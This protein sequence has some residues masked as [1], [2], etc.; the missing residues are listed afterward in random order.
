MLELSTLQAGTADALLHEE[1]GVCVRDWTGPTG[2]VGVRA[3]VGSAWSWMVLDGVA[4]Y[5]F[6]RG[7]N[8]VEAIPVEQATPAM[9][10]DYYRRHI[11]PLVMQA[12]GLEVLHASANLYAGGVL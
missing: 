9:V 4:T 1:H 8:R 5:R 11:L 6:R 12:N 3:Y 7:S 10:E 2:G